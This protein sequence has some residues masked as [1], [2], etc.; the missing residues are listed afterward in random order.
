[1]KYLK[2]LFLN[3]AILLASCSSQQQAMRVGSV[4]KDAK[5][6]SFAY[7]DLIEAHSPTIDSLAKVSSDKYKRQT[8]KIGGRTYYLYY[9]YTMKA[10]VTLTQFPITNEEEL[11]I[12]KQFTDNV[13]VSHKY[14]T[15]LRQEFSEDQ[16]LDIVRDKVE[17][18]DSVDFSVRDVEYILERVVYSQKRDP[19]TLI[20][21][22]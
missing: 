8:V 11:A 18:F 9:Q 21:Q 15:N 3:G 12:R 5:T 10:S 16:L 22:K 1:M 13:V 20:L 4:S 17:C 6:K 19:N 2:L 7:S 14:L